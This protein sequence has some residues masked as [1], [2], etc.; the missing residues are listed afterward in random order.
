[1]CM[2]D[3]SMCLHCVGCV[4]LVTKKAKREPGVV[5]HTFNP[6][7]REAEAGRLLSSSPAWSRKTN[8]QANKKKPKEDKRSFG[9]DSL[10]NCGGLNENGPHRPTDTWSPESDTFERTYISRQPWAPGCPRKRRFPI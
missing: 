4:Y 2:S 5:A 8:K 7:T 6:S 1:M 3:L 9:S 10:K